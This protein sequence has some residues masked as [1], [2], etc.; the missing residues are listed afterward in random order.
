MTVSMSVLVGV[1]ITDSKLTSTT[2]PEPSSGEVAWNAA[3]SYAVG[4]QV[5]RAT[6]HR[7]YAALVAGSDA[8]LPEN[9]P[10]RWFDMGPT[11]RWACLDG[12]SSTQTVAASPAT[13]VLHPGHHNAF[14][15]GGADVDILDITVKS[16]PGGPTIYT[17]TVAM[18]TSQPGDYYEHFFDPF[19]P[20]RDYLASSIEPYLDAEISITLS[21]GSGQVKFAVLRVG[22]LRELGRTLKGAR[23][24]PKSH[25]RITVDAEGNNKINRGKRAKDMSATALVSLDEANSVLE[26]ITDLLD[27]PSV[28]ICTDL[29]KYAGLRTYGLGSAELSHDSS[30][31]AL[32]NLSV[33]GLI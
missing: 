9:T 6:T 20:L 11:N 30:T 13:Y 1:D 14:Y 28:W 4:A 27:V 33:I 24:K 19:K 31:H 16:S 29:E 22:D 26:T 23:A 12:E 8:G 15:I 21:S 18:E 32:L 5:I 17:K 3:S 2:V 7:R 10:L 25:S